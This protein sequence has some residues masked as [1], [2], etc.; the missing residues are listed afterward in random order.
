LK[1]DEIKKPIKKNKRP[2]TKNKNI[3]DL[4]SKPV[5]SINQVT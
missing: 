1:K 4:M 3:L 2:K 5:K